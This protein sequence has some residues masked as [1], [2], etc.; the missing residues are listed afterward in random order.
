MG[1]LSVDDNDQRR[2]LGEIDNNNNNIENTTD[3][4]SIYIRR[5]NGINSSNHLKYLQNINNIIPNSQCR[6]R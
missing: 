5:L 2:S 1:A 6:F 3:N 4:N